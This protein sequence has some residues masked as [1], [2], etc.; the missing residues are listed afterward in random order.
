MHFSEEID[1]IASQLPEGHELGALIK[2]AEYE[3]QS[4]EMLKNEY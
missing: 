2:H 3:N 1:N 4:L